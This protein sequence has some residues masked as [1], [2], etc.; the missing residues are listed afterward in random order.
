MTIPHKY[1]YIALGVI[2]LSLVGY[3]AFKEYNS[4]YGQIQKQNAEL[5]KEVDK[6]ERLVH[7]LGVERKLRTDTIREIKTQLKINEKSY[8]NEIA[9][10]LSADYRTTDSVYWVNSRRFDS[11]FYA[12]QFNPR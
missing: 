8:Y 5:L 6:I 7:D 3:L 1:I 2:I 4:P 11:S 9:Y 12:G 10:I